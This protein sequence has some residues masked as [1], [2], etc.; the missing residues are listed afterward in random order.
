MIARVDCGF[1]GGEVV[2]P[3]VA[4]RDT[5]P[6]G[7]VQLS[8]TQASYGAELVNCAVAPT[9]A[10]AEQF[11]TGHDVTAAFDIYSR[12]P[13][14]AVADAYEVRGWQCRPRGGWSRW[15]NPFTGTDMGYVLRVE[16]VGYRAGQPAGEGVSRG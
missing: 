13:V 9:V 10:D 14:D 6:L 4:A 5:D 8:Y 12:S 1:P 7:D 16:A 2:T 11:T 15:S 3:L